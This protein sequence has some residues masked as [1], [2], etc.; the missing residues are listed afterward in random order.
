MATHQPVESL[1]LHALLLVVALVVAIA[2]QGAY[3]GTGQ[4][5][6]AVVLVL[7]L[8]A[9]LR[10]RPW[11][12]DDALLPP[13]WAGAAL[14]A[15][16][17]VSAAA[18]G[19]ITDARPISALLAGVVVVL[20]AVRRLTW[21]QRDALAAAVVA[22]GG[23]LPPPAGLGSSGGLHPGRWRIRGCGGRPPP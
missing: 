5:T 4:R 13:V 15:W 3:Y 2:A 16:A 21:G 18:A 11:S 22:V 8:F 17:A 23:W 7:A 10:V 6:V 19:D 20:V 9:A 14:A 1:P 12:R